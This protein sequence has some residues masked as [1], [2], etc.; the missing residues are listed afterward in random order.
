SQRAFLWTLRATVQARDIASAARRQP[1]WKF[2]VRRAETAQ[3]NSPLER[4]APRQISRATAR[5][6]HIKTCNAQIAKALI[7]KGHQRGPRAI[8][9]EFSRQRPL[10]M[11]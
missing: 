1:V 2:L 3:I 5:P 4:R 11:P 8:R 10:P 6:F 7:I 9:R